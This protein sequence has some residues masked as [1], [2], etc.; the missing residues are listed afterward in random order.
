MGR[1]ASWSLGV[2]SRGVNSRLRIYLPVLLWDDV[3]VQLLGDA[4]E[5]GLNDLR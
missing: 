2:N 5:D 4:G 1:T 3:D